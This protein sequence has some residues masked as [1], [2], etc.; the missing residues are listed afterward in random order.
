MI[1]SI[2]QAAFLQAKADFRPQLRG[3]G[4]LSFIF[5]PLFFVGIF[6]SVSNP[7]TTIVSTTIGAVLAASLI[8][9]FAAYTS[10]QLPQEM[11]IEHL[12][13][14]MLRVKF[15]PFGIPAWM[16]GKAISL[17]IF[18][19]SQTLLFM[20]ASA[21]VLPDFSF[22]ITQYLL[23]LLVLL[24]S[25]VANTPIA[26]L[27]GTLTRDTWSTMLVYLG[28]MGLF[29]ISGVA[30]PLTLLPSWLA[31]FPYI[32]PGYWGSYLSR[33]VFLDEQTRT[34]FGDVPGYSWLALLIL[35]VWIV[36]GFTLAAFA[37]R[38]SFMKETTSVLISRRHKID[39]Q[40]GM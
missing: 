29:A 18:S 27:F 8:G 24:I 1:K 22:S 16:I 2:L 11:Y 12:N 17:S 35:L 33:M 38:R 21:L 10:I 13:G 39:S 25:L 23:A 28:M 19:L 7:D 26:F 9:G 31:W 30:V 34:F 4:I 36:V 37:I 14:T 32:T 5:F 40:L 15:L 3:L 6:W 20:F